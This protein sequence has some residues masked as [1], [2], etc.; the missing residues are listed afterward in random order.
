M[1]IGKEICNELKAV[2]RRI[3]EE[4]GI[5]LEMPECTHQGPCPGTCPHCEQE[6]RQLETALA[7]RLRL[8]KAATVAGLALGLAVGNVHGANGMQNTVYGHEDSAPR[9]SA[10]RTQDTEPIKV[11][12][13]IL[14]EKSKEPIPLV[15]VVFKQADT[16]ILCAVT[17]WDG[18]F[19]AE[20]PE[21]EYDI[22]LMFIGYYR[23][24]IKVNITRANRKL[25]DIMLTPSATL[26]DGVVV[27]EHGQP[28]IEMDPYGSTQH[29]EI[30]GVKVNVR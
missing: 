18:I 11:T 12:G 19:K 17:D 26:L 23:K 6:L 13:T 14:D 27:I 24:N 7:D 10:L 4:N 20:L 9:Y 25:G 2:R 3:A 5:P 8:G 29:M 21:G 15:Y 28:L 22:D 16:V 30:E 1:N